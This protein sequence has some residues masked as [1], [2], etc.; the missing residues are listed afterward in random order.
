MADCSVVLGAHAR[1][2]S[3]RRGGTETQESVRRDQLRPLVPESPVRVGLSHWMPAVAVYL[4]AIPPIDVTLT[5]GLL[6]HFFF[7]F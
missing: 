4:A 1:A 3:P 2:G 7:F 6:R 5:A